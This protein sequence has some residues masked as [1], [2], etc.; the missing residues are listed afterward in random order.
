MVALALDLE[1]RIRTDGRLSLDD[2]MR[3]LWKRYGIETKGGV[4]HG[5]FEELAQDVSGLDLGAFFREN[6]RGTVDPPVGILL[7]QFGI[8]LQMRSAISAS[9]VGG[10]A[11]QEKERLGGWLGIRAR[12]DAGCV[13]VATVL[14]ASP[15]QIAGISSGD[16]LVAIDGLKVTEKSFERRLSRCESGDTARIV[17]FRGDEL[18]EFAAIA[19]ER[20]RDTC[21][22]QIESDA[23]GDCR[24]RR[25]KWWHSSHNS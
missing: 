25:D 5:G 3:T 19:A 24:G 11:V 1:I 21:Y 2:V 12:A 17:V 20:P 23:R 16:E 22:L 10:N 9:D 18:L 13:R 4:P 14:E 8:R 6:L 15:A 7:A